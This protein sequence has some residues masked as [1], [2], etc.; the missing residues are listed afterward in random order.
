MAKPGIGWE[1]ILTIYEEGRERVIIFAQAVRYFYTR[2]AIYKAFVIST[3]VLQFT[4]HSLFLH[5]E[6]ASE[7]A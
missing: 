2:L 7:Y 5:T 6:C 4:K 3:H 1:D